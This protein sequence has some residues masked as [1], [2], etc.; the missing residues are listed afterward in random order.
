MF[1]SIVESGLN[2]FPGATVIIALADGKKVDAA[3]VAAPDPAGIEAVR[4]RC[5]FRYTREYMHGT[6]ILGGRIVDI[7]DVE[8]APAELAV[9][10]ARLAATGYGHARIMP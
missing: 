10:T 8:N 6:T 7:P 3:A 9:S 4:R 1:N 5:P 2:L